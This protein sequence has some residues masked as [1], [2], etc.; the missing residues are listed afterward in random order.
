M[1]PY[2]QL[3]R[4]ADV[5]VADQEPG[6]PLEEIALGG[7]QALHQARRR[8]HFEARRLVR[9]RRPPLRSSAIA[10]ACTNSATPPARLPTK[11]PAQAGP[12]RAC[13]RRELDDRRLVEKGPAVDLDDEAEQF[14]SAG[15]LRKNQDQ[16]HPFRPIHDHVLPGVADSGSCQRID[17]AGER[18]RLFPFGRLGDARLQFGNVETVCLIDRPGSAWAFGNGEIARGLSRPPAASSCSR[19]GKTRRSRT[20]MG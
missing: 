10:A 9:Q 13:R 2:R 17:L 4:G 11:A 16:Q 3:H 7:L 5:A 1:L 18:E 14:R 20:G 19:K 6:V 12:K 15:R 8:L